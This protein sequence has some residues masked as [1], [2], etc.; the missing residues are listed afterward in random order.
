MS[1]IEVGDRVKIKAGRTDT[2]KKLSGQSGIITAGP[3]KASF[4]IDGGWNIYYLLDVASGGLW[5]DELI[6]ETGDWDK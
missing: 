6:Q 1:K 2:S 3:V 5:E 4:Q